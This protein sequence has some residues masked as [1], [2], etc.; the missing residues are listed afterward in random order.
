VLDAGARH[1]VTTGSGINRE[2][3]VRGSVQ[4]VEVSPLRRLAPSHGFTDHTPHVDTRVNVDMRHTL[5]KSTRHVG[6][7]NRTLGHHT[8]IPSP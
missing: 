8:Q 6:G 3:V 1:L 4:A 7:T 2:F 5:D